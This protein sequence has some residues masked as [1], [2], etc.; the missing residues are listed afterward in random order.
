MSPME[1]NIL[2]FIYNLEF[3]IFIKRILNSPNIYL[4]G[5]FII[6]KVYYQL[7]I[8]LFYDEYTDKKIPGAYIL[9]N[10]KYEKSYIKILYNYN[11]KY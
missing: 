9:I 11:R 7:L 6:T 8:L 10:N 1:K 2:V 4:D 5:T 3:P